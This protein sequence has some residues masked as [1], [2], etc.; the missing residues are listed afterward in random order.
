GDGRQVPSP[1][2]VAVDEHALA[3]DDGG[4]DL[5]E[6]AGGRAE[7]A[8]GDAPDDV[9]HRLA[10]V[11]GVVARLVEEAPQPCREAIAAPQLEAVAGAPGAAG[12]NRAAGA[13]R[14][15]ARDTPRRGGQ[16][17]A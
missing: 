12:R 10:L 15:R 4:R 2:A 13:R 17:G 8:G 14:G 3:G 11:G 7:E 6:A 1:A 5:V 9:G 16:R